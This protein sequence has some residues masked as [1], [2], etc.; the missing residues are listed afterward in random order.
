MMKVQYMPEVIVTVFNKHGDWVDSIRRRKRNDKV[1]YKYQWHRLIDG[2][3]IIRS[4]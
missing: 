4:K 2:S 1:F 3:Y